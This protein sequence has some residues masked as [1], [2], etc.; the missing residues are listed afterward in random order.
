VPLETG[1]VIRS[2]NGEPMKTL[3]QLRDALAKL[4]PG[5]SVALQIQRDDRL[6]FTTFTTE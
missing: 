4:P 1:D 2:L 6:M 5:S 3:D